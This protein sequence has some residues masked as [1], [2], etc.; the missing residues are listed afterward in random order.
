MKSQMIPVG[1]ALVLGGIVGFALA[2]KGEKPPMD[3][4]SVKP[5]AT[6]QVTCPHCGQAFPIVLRDN[7]G[8]Q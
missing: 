8:A 2:P 7:R 4:V 6:P 5:I 1:I 3:S